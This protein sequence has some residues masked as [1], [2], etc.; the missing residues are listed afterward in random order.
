MTYI[1]KLIRTYAYWH[2]IRLIT[3]RIHITY[4]I[5]VIYA[6]YAKFRVIADLFQSKLTEESNIQWSNHSILIFYTVCDVFTFNP[7]LHPFEFSFHKIF[8]SF[9]TL[10][11]EF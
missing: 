4:C 3:T 9:S 2:I 1:S 6:I 10:D 8:V 5:Y 7:Y 11:R